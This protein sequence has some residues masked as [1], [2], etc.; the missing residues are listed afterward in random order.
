MF[1]TWVTIVAAPMIVF[2]GMCVT[3]GG[4]Y[5]ASK[6]LMKLGMMYLG[7]L[8]VVAGVVLALSPSLP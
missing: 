4:Y 1:N 5:P 2:G 8:F 3:T 7:M 6:R